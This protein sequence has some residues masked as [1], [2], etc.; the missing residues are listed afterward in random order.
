MEFKHLAFFI[1]L[2]SVIPMTFMCMFS[3]KFIKAC[4]YLI[5]A[6]QIFYQQTAIN[7]MSNPHY[8]GTALGFEISIIHLISYSLLIGML[9]RQW[10]IK[11]IF[12]GTLSY[13]IYYIICIMTLSSSP[14]LK[15]SCFELF[16]MFNLFCVYLAV[17]NYLYLTHDFDSFIWGLATIILA[18][19]FVAF[20]M[21]YIQGRVQVPGIFSHQ[22]CAGMFMCL[23]GPIF[24]SRI[25]NKKDNILKSVFFMIIFLMAFLCALFTYSRGSLA[26]F[27]LACAIT[28]FLSLIFNLNFKTIMVLIITGL[29]GILACAYSAPTIINRFTNATPA[30]AAM[31]VMLA[32]VAVKIMKDKP[33]LGCGIN[34]WGI[35][36]KSPRY[37]KYQENFNFEE[38]DFIGIVETTYLLV[39]AECGFLGLGAL[40]CWYLYHL[41]LAVLQSFHWRHTD[42]FYI[43]S[44]LVGGFIA[45]YLQSTLEWVLK[46]QV[47]FCTLFCC[48]AMVAAL[49]QGIKEHTTLSKLE[50]II[51][52]KERK[53]KLR[54]EAQQSEASP[55]LTPP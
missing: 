39:G 27:P 16:K 11:F 37:N 20:K 4:I 19:F 30:S 17:V 45:N 23:V 31:R 49:A 12:P 29:L 54:E 46:Q 9:L 18:S 22:N 15:Y 5:I 34:T 25:L 26:C 24:L 51:A 55:Q 35:V 32:D 47:N 42:Y 10:P 3:Q 33:L 41:F 50:E 38:G 52:Q 14:N 21:K 36:G 8:K 7:F 44:G 43:P 2:L 48:F 53:R 40:I 13:L 28:I 1:A 6:F